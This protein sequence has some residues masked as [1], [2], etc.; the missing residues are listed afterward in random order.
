MYTPLYQV[1]TREKDHVDWFTAARVCDELDP[2]RFISREELVLFEKQREIEI[3]TLKARMVELLEKYQNTAL[4]FL[5]N[6][7]EKTK[8]SLD[9]QWDEI[10]SF[11]VK[12]SERTNEIEDMWNKRVHQMDKWADERKKE[13]ENRQEQRKLI[14]DMHK[15][16]AERE[17][18]QE[19][20]IAAM[21]KCE[22]LRREEQDKRETERDERQ[23]QFMAEMERR[24]TL[25]QE[26]QD[27][28]EA[29]RHAENRQAYRKL[30]ADM[31]K[32]E[33]ER[34]AKQRRFIAEMNKR[35]ALRKAEHVCS[36]SRSLR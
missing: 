12:V 13:K 10:R 33:A 9:Q 7:D 6:S 32:R 28:R 20:F 25:R 8:E 15:R 1:L 24:E 23:Q 2:A 36:S 27:K 3:T 30:V 5:S 29:A 17:A 18:R 31:H 16:E 19:Q 14:A 11:L 4:V 26:E 34:E 21:E 35:G 22:A